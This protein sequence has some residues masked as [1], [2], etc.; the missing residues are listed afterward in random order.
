MSNLASNALEH[1]GCGF[2]VTD[3][4]LGAFSSVNKPACWIVLSP[5][6]LPAVERA[7]LEQFA[8][9]V[10]PEQ[11]GQLTPTRT[12][13][14]GMAWGFIDQEGRLVVLVTNLARGESAVRLD[15]SGL[16]D[17]TFA[18]TD[19]LTGET[20]AQVTASG[21]AAQMIVNLADYDTRVLVF[22]AAAVP[23]L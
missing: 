22:P 13:A 21:G 6:R 15:L 8:P 11:A 19:A 10:T 7:R 18:P 17:G 12:S 14:N 23:N 4:A 9:V 5:E 20:V 16:A 2:Y 1:V 3:A